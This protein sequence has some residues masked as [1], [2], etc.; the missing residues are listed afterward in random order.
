MSN[1]SQRNYGGEMDDDE[2]ID[3]NEEEFM[4]MDEV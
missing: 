3:E 1:R 2:E 4:D